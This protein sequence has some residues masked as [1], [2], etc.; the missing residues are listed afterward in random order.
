MKCVNHGD[1]EAVVQCAGCEKPLCSYC[2]ES[3]DE[4]G[5]CYCFDCAIS[6]NLSDFRGKEAKHRAEEEEREAKKGKLSRKAI[7]MLVIA[8]V[9]I[10]GEG[11]FILYTRLTQR[12]STPAITKEQEVVWERDECIMRMQKVRDALAAY[13]AD[14]N[15]Q[16]PPSLYEI[17]GSYLKEEPVCP[18]TKEPYIYENLGNDYRLSCPNPDVHS[19]SQVTSSANEVPHY[20]P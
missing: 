5:N 14:H 10:V 3:Q 16:Y 1:M 18:K 8:A 19:A 6:M 13:W 9:L 4:N 20:D 15:Q 2:V 7:V 12:K 11:G 17:T